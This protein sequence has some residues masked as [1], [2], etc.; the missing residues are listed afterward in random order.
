MSN[1][2]KLAEE[3]AALSG[4]LAPIV[5]PVMEV[6]CLFCHFG[7]YFAPILIPFIGM[8]TPGP[9]LSLVCCLSI[10]SLIFICTIPATTIESKDKS[11]PKKNYWSRFTFAFIVYYIIMLV[12]MCIVVKKVCKVEEV[13]ENVG[14]NPLGAFKDYASSAMSQPQPSQHSNQFTNY[15]SSHPT[16][17]QHQSS[18]NNFASNF[19]KYGQQF[20][21]R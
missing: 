11:A 6:V 16:F 19:S 20:M 4:P 21:K 9:L 15:I 8:F 18:F 13:V 14:T 10:I 1:C 7:K 5:G 12:F 17:Q 2:G 3:A